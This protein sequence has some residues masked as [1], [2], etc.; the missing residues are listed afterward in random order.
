M[1]FKHSEVNVKG[2]IKKRFGRKYGRKDI[3]EKTF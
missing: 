3:F 1:N 2:N